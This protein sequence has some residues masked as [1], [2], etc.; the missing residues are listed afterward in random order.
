MAR[1]YWV[2]P[3][4][5]L[6]TADGAAYT[7][8]TTLTNVSPV[9]DIVTPANLFEVGTR[10]E[11]FCVFQYSNTGTP[12]LTLGLYSGTIGQAISGAAT[13]AVSSAI[14]TVAST[15]RAC[16]MEG[17]GQITSVGTAGVVRAMGEITNV[18]SG[19]TDMA[20]ATS[21]MANT[22]IDTTVARY[23]AIGAT[24]SATGTA[25]TMTVKYFGIRLVS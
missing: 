1:Q 8:S 9:P 4:P 18:S 17:H 6:H 22:T 15:G 3:L 21:P 16:R 7:N 10:F 5:P 23:W 25:N 11:W 13:P 24:W 14:T 2:A 19:G 20:P 12:T